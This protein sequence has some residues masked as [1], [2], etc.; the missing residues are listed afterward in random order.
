MRRLLM[1]LLQNCFSMSN[2]QL[3]QKPKP[4]EKG[5]TISVQK[6]KN[7]T[8]DDQVNVN[9]RPKG[10]IITKEGPKVVPIKDAISK[11]KEKMKEVE[12]EKR[13]KPS[14]SQI[15]ADEQLARK[16]VEDEQMEI[17]KENQDAE[18]ARRKLK[19]QLI[20]RSSWII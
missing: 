16:I 8:A 5:I 6:E 10:V 13:M 4:K 11:G 14:Q 15:D 3:S 1:R 12:V 18:L 2:N 9:L 17:L 7:A 20:R 19:Q